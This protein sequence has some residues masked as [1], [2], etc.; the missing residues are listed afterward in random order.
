MI[1]HRFRLALLAALSLGAARAQEAKPFLSPMFTDNM[2]LQRG[3]KAPVW[4]WTKPG[5]EVTVTVQ[6]KTARAKAG[7]DGKWVAK[8]GPLTAGG[9]M[10]VDVVGSSQ[11][12]LDNVLVGDVWICSGQSNMEMGLRYVNNG[13][14]EI[15]GATDPDIRVFRVP[16]TVAL[17]PLETPP[18][19]PWQIGSPRT[20]GEGAA[21][22]S[23]AAY[24]FARELRRKVGV[25]IGLVQT[26]WGGTYAESWTSR[27]VLAKGFPEMADGLK[28]LDN[29]IAEGKPQTSPYI[30]SSLYN[31]MIAPV[32]P[33]GIKGA[34][35]YQ[36]EANA[37]HAFR[38]RDLLPAMITDW[39]SRW[40]Q[41][42]F[43]F[44]IVQLANY[45]NTQS[46]PAESEWA[47]LREAQLMTFEN[48]PNTGLA[49]TIDIGEE[50]DIHPRNKQEVGRRLA[51]AAERVAYGRRGVAW[52]G[53]IYKGM[54]VK[55]SQALLSFRFTD[56]GLAAKG[57]KLTGFQIAGSDRKW[58][59]ADASIS[60]KTVVVSSPSVSQPVAV[61]YAWGSNPI[62][63]LYNGAGL[64]A[65]PFRTDDWPGMTVPK[66]AK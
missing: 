33:F 10:H 41:K 30:L 44:L 58:F 59:W 45:M 53:P 21:G 3:I 18:G 37:N 20:M 48:L 11:A 39:R 31:G 40:G 13:D 49:V 5:E 42:D 15:A 7:A 54:K 57:D 62:C 2:V 51:L 60:G 27:E 46:Q 36:G 56:G 32:I 23:A 64:P 29:W 19:G 22:M 61:R 6:G 16:H 4:G 1:K 65:S 24:F 17:K 28:N 14:A 52:S 8:V 43:P 47:E 66:P 12:M 26:C 34:I 38:Y 50:K 9:P 55:G 25:P 63:N 35:W